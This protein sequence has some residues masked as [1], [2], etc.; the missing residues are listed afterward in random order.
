MQILYIPLKNIVY[1][2]FWQLSLPGLASAD[3]WVNEYNRQG[4]ICDGCFDALGNGSF[5]KDHHSTF[6][7]DPFQARGLSLTNHKAW[8]IMG[9]R[10]WVLSGWSHTNRFACQYECERKHLA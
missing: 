3:L 9:Q 4:S 8:L 2:V 10:G 5:V 7:R 6:P 1:E